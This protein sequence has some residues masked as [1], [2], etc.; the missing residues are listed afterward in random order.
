[1]PSYQIAHSFQHLFPTVPILPFRKVGYDHGRRAVTLRFRAYLATLCL[2]FESGGLVPGHSGAHP[3]L[4]SDVFALVYS[5]TTI[6][7]RRNKWSG[8]IATLKV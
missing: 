6:P 7:S 3:C 5:A 2:V 4:R 8:L 1:M